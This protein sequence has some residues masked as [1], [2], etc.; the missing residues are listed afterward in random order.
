ME[1]CMLRRLLRTNVSI[2]LIISNDAFALRY[3]SLF[4]GGG[5]RGGGG[6]GGGGDRY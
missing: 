3:H 5:G 4:E 2:P 6:Y 1:V